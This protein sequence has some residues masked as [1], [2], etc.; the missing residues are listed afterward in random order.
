MF[1]ARACFH[2]KV[3]VFTV[4]SLGMLEH[5]ILL[6]GSVADLHVFLKSRFPVFAPYALVRENREIPQYA[7]LQPDAVMTLS[8]LPFTC[9]SIVGFA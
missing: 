1:D 9:F 6:F 5:G 2:R 3:I 4:M 8:L 7:M